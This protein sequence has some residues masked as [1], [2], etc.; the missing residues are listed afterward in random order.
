MVLPNPK[1]LAALGFSNYTTLR[2]NMLNTLFNLKANQYSGGD[3]TDPVQVYSV[4]V[5]LLMQAV[6]NMAQAKSLAQTE[7]QDEQK[8]SAAEK[9]AIIDLIVGI[10]L[11]VH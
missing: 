9:Q 4:S 5:F 1:D 10:V 8:Q 11:M 6:D 3:Q 2:N 7:Q